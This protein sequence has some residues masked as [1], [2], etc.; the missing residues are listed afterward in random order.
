MVWDRPEAWGKEE[1][2]ELLMAAVAVADITAVAV[3]VMA[4]AAAVHLMH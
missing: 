4:V 3:V 2:E 1:M